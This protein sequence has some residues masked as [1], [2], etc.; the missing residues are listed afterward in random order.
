LGGISHR[1]PIPWN[2]LEYDTTKNGYLEPLDK[3]NLEWAPRHAIDEVPDYD[4]AY[5]S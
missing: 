5:N 1:Y 2:M 3:A 4:D